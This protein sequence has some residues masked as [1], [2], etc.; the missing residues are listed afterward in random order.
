MIL[1]AGFGVRMRPLT[2]DRPKPLIEVAG[3]ALIDYG[4][5]R[6]HEAGVQR[7]VVNGHYRAEQIALWAKQQTAPHI[8]F[9]DEQ[10]EILIQV[11]AS[12]KP[13]RSWP[14][15]FFCT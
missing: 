2:N 11:A 14:P 15:A 3:K 8:V 13:F 5:D 7:A 4:F 6:L 12:Q 1:A 9:S 10:A